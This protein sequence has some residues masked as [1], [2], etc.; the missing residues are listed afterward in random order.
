MHVVVH[1]LLGEGLTDLLIILL[2]VLPIAVARTI[3]HLDLFLTSQ[4][5]V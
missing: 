1:V 4:L 5:L 2:L 3:S